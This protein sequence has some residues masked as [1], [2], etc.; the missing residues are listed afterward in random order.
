MFRR[1]LVGI[2]L[3]IAVFFGGTVAQAD[4]QHFHLVRTVTFE[5][6]DV[7]LDLWT[8]GILRVTD[9]KLP[10]GFADWTAK[11]IAKN[12]GVCVMTVWS[13]HDDAEQGTWLHRAAL[14]EC[15]AKIPTFTNT[16]VPIVLR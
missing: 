14:E 6:N 7:L 10:Y 2:G 8:G 12:R 11:E 4:H 15:S 9:A 1:S 5:G 16:Y 13:H 3:L